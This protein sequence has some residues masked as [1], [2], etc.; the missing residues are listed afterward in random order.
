MG[1]VGQGDAGGASSDGRAGVG[2]HVCLRTRE[3]GR[4]GLASL[5]GDR[6]KGGSVYLFLV[7]VFAEEVS[8]RAD[9]GGAILGYGYVSAMICGLGASCG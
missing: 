3:G 7:L 2:A 9:G 4:C 8:S 5:A 6:C 1:D